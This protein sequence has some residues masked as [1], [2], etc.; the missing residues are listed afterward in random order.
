MQPL[1]TELLNLPGRDV[2]D[3]KIFDDKIILE[4]EAHTV[5]A[6]YPRCQTEST[7]LHQNHGYFMRDLSLMG[8]SV[9]L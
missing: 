1:F 2:E 9:L 7:Y 3:Y 5:R 6:V 4:I 8:R